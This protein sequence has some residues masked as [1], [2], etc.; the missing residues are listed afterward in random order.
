MKRFGKYAE[1]ESS[2]SQIKTMQ[3]FYTFVFTLCYIILL[4]YI[5]LYYI[6]WFVTSRQTYGGQCTLYVYVVYRR[7]FR[8][9]TTPVSTRLVANMLTNL[10]I[11][12]NTSSIG[13]SWNRSRL[14]RQTPAVTWQWP[15][16]HVTL[17]T[18]WPLTHA[19]LKGH[20]PQHCSRTT[21]AAWGHTVHTTRNVKKAS[22]DCAYRPRRWRE[23]DAPARWC[24]R[25]REGYIR[26]IV[27]CEIRSVIKFLNAKNVRPAEI[28]RKFC[29]VYGEN[30]MS[31]RL[32]RRCCRMFSEGRTNV[33]DDDRSGL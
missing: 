11:L 4:Y 22:F 13:V 7:R 23:R 6:T 14:P 12:F 33:H 8:G 20:T 27:S 25:S 17:S 30:A 31:D 2:F 21:A 28:Y 32:V 24:L 5:I 26:H 10:F 16:L 15:L 19:M 29:E 9:S 3:T 18:P 1:L